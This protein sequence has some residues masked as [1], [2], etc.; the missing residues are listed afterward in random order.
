VQEHLEQRKIKCIS[1]LFLF[2]CF[3]L[4]QVAARCGNRVKI[5]ARNEDVVEMINS[6]HINPHYLSEYELSDLITASTSVQEV[7]EG[8]NFA[9]LALPTQLVPPSSIR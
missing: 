2:T 5:Y 8:A 7:L 4:A 6:N 3:S 1:L 9:I